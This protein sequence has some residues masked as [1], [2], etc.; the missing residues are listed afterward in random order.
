MTVLAPPVI[1]AEA[2]L[3]PYSGVPQIALDATNTEVFNV[4]G[5]MD[6][7]FEE[8]IGT[9]VAETN[10]LVG[11]SNFVALDGAFSLVMTALAN[12]AMSARVGPYP[13]LPSTLYTYAAAYFAAFATETVR[14]DIE[15]YLGDT[16]VSTTTGPTSTDSATRPWLPE[17]SLPTVTSPSGIDSAYIVFNVVNAAG[18]VANPA[19][20]TITPTGASGGSSYHYQVT[21][22]TPY[23]ETTASPLG[24]TVTGNAVLSVT[25]FNHLSWSA[26]TGATAYNVYRSP[27]ATCA[28]LAADFPTCASLIAD[29]ATCSALLGFA[30]TPTFL[31][32]TASATYNDTGHA[33][34]G[35]LAPLINTT[36]ERHYVD[37]V[38]LFP[39][40]VTQWGIFAT[41]VITILRSDGQYVIGAS[42]LFPLALPSDNSR[43]TI[44]DYTAAYGLPV[45]YVANLVSSSSAISPPSAPTLPVVMGQAPDTLTLYNRLGWAKDEDTSGQ[46]LD[47]LSGIGE[48]VQ[49]LDSLF[50]DQ[51]DNEGNYYPGPS[52]LL[53]IN[54]CPTNMLAWLGQFVGVRVDPTQRDDQQRYSILAEAGFKRGTPGAILAAANQ[55]VRAG[56][57]A[58]IAERDTSPYHLTITIPETGIEGPGS[59]LVLS[60]SYPSCSA[61]AADVATCADLWEGTTAVSAAVLA[62]IPAGLGA[63][64]T[65][66]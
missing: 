38:G 22:V 27:K 26:V 23:G 50:V 29:F 35:V 11:H 63:T 15:W 4:V 45:T 6:A 13:A 2:Q 57:T 47:W 52:Q 51:I 59:C 8:G 54:R 36:A 33:T 34:T 1:T 19:M 20:P 66:V 10:C 32:S 49:G 7:S 58:S 37:E 31:A 62:A 9:A 61:L 55:Y 3:N 64:V 24:S 56:S 46:L 53:D 44:V 5:E 21:A 14:T 25:N 42:P 28:A 40:T 12:G 48:M 60:R 30:A 17:T 16:P 65:F 43:V 41:G 39:G 18:P